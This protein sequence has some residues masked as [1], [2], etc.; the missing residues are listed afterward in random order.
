MVASVPQIL[1]NITLTLKTTA[2]TATDF[3]MDV[4]DAA[5]VPTAG[6]EQKV[7][8]LDGIVHQ[9]VAVESWSLDLTCV[10]DWDSSRPGLAHYLYTNKGELLTFIFND[11]DTALSA[12][13]P[14]M[15]GT[16]R[17]VPISYGG[18]GNTYAEATVSMPITGVPTVDITP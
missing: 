13:K 8:T 11:T 7:T 3:S 4:I 10:V 5:I 9:D 1:K 15:T 12:T 14:G 16:C 18:A 6:D 17:A 2:G